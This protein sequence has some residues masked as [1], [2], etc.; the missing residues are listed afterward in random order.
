SPLL[1]FILFSAALISSM[2]AFMSKENSF[3]L[4]A[5]I[6]LVELLFIS[7][8]FAGKIIKSIKWQ[9]WLILFIIILMLLPLGE[10]YWNSILNGYN[11]RHFTLAE[12]LL[13]QF[14]I[15]VIYISLLLLPLPQRLNLD[16]DIPLSTSLLS[17]PTTLVCLFLLTL[18]LIT[19]IQ[20]KKTNPFIAFGV[21]WFF[22]NLIIESSMVPL[23]LIFEHR[24]YLPSI[25]FFITVI[26][27]IDTVLF[28]VTSNEKQ[29]YRNIFL[30]VIICVSCILSILTTMRNHVWR[31]P[32]SLW[33]DCAKK[34]PNKAR[35]MI[36]Y[37][38]ALIES[39]SYDEALAALDKGI[40]LG[41]KYREEYIVAVAN[42]TSIHFIK[43]EFE[44]ARRR[45]EECLNT[46]TTEFDGSGFPKLALNLA[47]TYRETGEPA[48]SLKILAK[49]FAFDPGATYL[50]K[51]MK[52][53]LTEVN[54]SIDET[55]EKLKLT[56]EPVEAPLI[57]A[58]LLL[59]LRQYEKC[60]TYLE[61][62]LEIDPDH[63]ESLET[64]KK[65][66]QKLQ[67]N[68]KAVHLSNIHNDQDFKNNR[69]FRTYMS[70]ADFITCNY[71]PLKFMVGGLVKRAIEI[72]PDNPF[73]HVYL[74]RRHMEMGHMEEALSTIEKSISDNSDFPP[75]L[76]LAGSCYMRVGKTGKAA[77]VYQH[78]LDL[79]HGH[80]A[81]N[82]HTR[83][84]Q[85]ALF[86]AEPQINTQS[87]TTRQ[88]DS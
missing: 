76:K 79:Y 88:I 78:L 72:R 63:P 75:L 40:A 41:E 25:G 74:A 85:K 60:A 27:A 9:Y 11:I 31:D 37:G 38:T 39:G 33:G 29:T 34:S 84:V 70:L 46:I 82:H 32:V 36:S 50:L 80:P 17:P 1:Q 28:H 3:T 44:E 19:G 47:R 57:I 86:N 71:S 49:G 56:G 35:P 5:A 54:N 7:P 14:R 67:E 30:L 22:L 81:W 6:L 45:G 83:V 55:R 13:T 24:L 77:I 43:G 53:M 51:A 48:K 66:L 58:L 64:K 10:N 15:V 87:T 69:M 23:E 65:L 52:I 12:R 21:L 20:T 4:P 26:S 42:I 59:D 18:L 8:C 62:A 16:H 61:K 73:A 2:L 68:A